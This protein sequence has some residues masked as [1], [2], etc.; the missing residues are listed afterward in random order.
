MNHSLLIYF[1]ADTWN[2]LQNSGALGRHH[3]AECMHSCLLHHSGHRGTL[4]TPSPREQFGLKFGS[5]KVWADLAAWRH[6]E[7]WTGVDQIQIFFEY[8]TLIF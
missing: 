4:T 5:V 6:R 1:R 7:Q 3:I 8:K 2:I